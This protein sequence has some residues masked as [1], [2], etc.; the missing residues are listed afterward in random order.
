MDLSIDMAFSFDPAWLSRR[1]VFGAWWPRALWASFVGGL[2]GPVRLHRRQDRRRF[3]F[4]HAVEHLQQH[5]HVQVVEDRRGVARLH[6]LVDLDET[7]P[8]AFVALLARGFELLE[9]RLQR[10]QLVDARGELLLGRGEHLLAR[11]ER[12]LPGLELDAAG[13][14][15][16]QQRALA[17]GD[18][19]LGGRGCLGGG[20]RGIRDRSGGL[21]AGLA[22]GFGVAGCAG[23]AAASAGT[24]RL[25]D[26]CASP[27]GR[28]ERTSST[29]LNASS[30]ASATLV[31]GSRRGTGI[32]SIGMSARH[33]Q[34][35]EQVALGLAAHARGVL[36]LGQGSCGRRRRGRG[37]GGRGGARRLRSTL[38][39]AAAR[40]D[41]R[42]HAVGQ[43]SPRSV[44]NIRSSLRAAAASTWRAI[45]RP[46][47]SAASRRRSM[48]AS[49]WRVLSLKPWTSSSSAAR[50]RFSTPSARS[51]RSA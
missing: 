21:L 44:R 34:R 1:L 28:T 13:A 19:R 42:V 40:A 20:L 45:W 18:G 22:D 36:G 46:A 29:V 2:P 24:T 37:E 49:A 39:D 6:R 25:D 23:G 48:P 11:G 14:Q 12:L 3:R 38:D 51:S 17:V 9:P 35:L 7:L 10:V 16:Q 31:T 41:Q 30:V 8:V 27:P 26:A 47:P 50:S 4:L 5:R 15:I 43:C 33:P 32:E